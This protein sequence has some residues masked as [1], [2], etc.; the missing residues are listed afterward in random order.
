[1]DIFLLVC[2]VHL[3]KH[4]VCY[5]LLQCQPFFSAKKKC[6]PNI[7]TDP[8][9][10]SADRHPFEL[11]KK[12][13]P[14]STDHGDPTAPPNRLGVFGWWFWGFSPDGFQV[15]VKTERFK[16]NKFDQIFLAHLR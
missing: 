10:H 9:E 2:L 15:C 14:F 5:G 16:G 11:F 7:S 4:M 1:M 13:P 8:H 12:L 6:R 3:G